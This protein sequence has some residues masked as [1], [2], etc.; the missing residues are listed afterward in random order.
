LSDIS[1]SVD[2]GHTAAAND[3][4]AG[5]KFLRIT[6]IQDGRVDWNSV[7]RCECS[8]AD[9]GKYKLH[10]NDIVFARTGAT[11]GKSYLLRDIPEQSVFASYLIRVRAKAS[12]VH[13]AYLARFFETQDYWGQIAKSSSGTAQGGVNASKLKALTLPLPPLAEQRRIAAILDKA[14]ALRT[15]RREAI[16]KLDQLLQSVF[17]DMFGDPVTNPKGWPMRR[18]GE[19][20]SDFVGG[21]N[22][23]CPDESSSPYRILKVSAVT[24]KV[25]RP[26]E[27]KPAPEAFEPA[28]EAIVRE[29]D[30]LFS[31]ANTTELVAATAYVWQT[32]ENLVLPDKLWKLQLAPKAIAMP[33]YLW[34][35]FKNDAFRNELSK[36]S[37]GTSGSMKNI[38]KSKLRAVPMPMPP[39]DIQERFSKIC[40]SIYKQLRAIDNALSNS[41]ALFSSLQIR[42][43]SG[44][45]TTHTEPAAANVRAQAPVSGVCMLKSKRKSVPADFD[46]ASLL[47]RK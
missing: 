47:R 42:A 14:N 20:F 23:A 5:P 31:R 44:A 39:I 8:P 22:V 6:D 29:G 43:F 21:K 41:E 16:A 4:I 17:L 19:I 25:Y 34:E 45:L 36:R 3:R 27:S 30:L 24:S 13:P 18:V 28:P 2:Y 12:E 1:A 7:P 40:H 38:S 32:P 15:K 46:V 9:L 10:A 35:L 11:T 26:D 37:S 33:L